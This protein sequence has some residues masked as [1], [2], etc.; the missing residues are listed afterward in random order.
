MAIT[1]VVGC[2]NNQVTGRKQMNLISN[3]QMM[4]YAEKDYD[5]VLA[6]SKVV[7]NTAV[8]NN[9]TSIGKRIVAAVEQY[10]TQQ[11][12]QAQLKDYKWEYNLI[13]S[14]EANAWCMPGGKIAVYTGILPITQNDDA[15]AVVMGHEIA[16]ALAEHGKE[17]ANQELAK[18]GGEMALQVFTAK[19]SSANREI[20]R[21]A[22]GV[23]SEYGV[24]LPFSRKQELE[25]DK[26]GLKFAA[27]AGFDPRTSIALWQRMEKLGG[28]N[29]PPEFASTHPAEQ[30]RIN[31]LN[32]Q[33]PEAMVLYNAA[34]K[35]VPVKK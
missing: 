6:H 24:I 5:T 28:A 14:T 30:T 25:A 15:L 22:F 17:R 11:G 34:K 31:E 18:Q 33:M 9:V 29:K 3:A 7:T 23:A 21:Q 2:S 32:K 1:V 12:L 4:A 13:E 26:L 16:H 27:M 20:F 35:T 8:S 19:Q 10:Y